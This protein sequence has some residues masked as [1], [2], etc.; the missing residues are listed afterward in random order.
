M[1]LED[2][3]YYPKQ[4][5]LFEGISFWTW[6]NLVVALKQCQDLLPASISS[7]ILEK[8]LD[9]L[10]VIAKFSSATTP[11]DKRKITEVCLIY[12]IEAPFLAKVRITND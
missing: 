2:P 10:I 9:C 4:R 12:L 5:N 3:T 7:S 6:T 8:I 1:A 11:T